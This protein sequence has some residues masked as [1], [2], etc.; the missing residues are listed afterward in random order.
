MTSDQAFAQSSF[1]ASQELEEV[2]ESLR[3]PHTFNSSLLLELNVT[4]RTTFSIRFQA[5]NELSNTILTGGRKVL[6]QNV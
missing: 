1:V 4:K 5:A 3:N 6:G 2:R